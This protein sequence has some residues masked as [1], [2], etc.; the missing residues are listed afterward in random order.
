MPLPDGIAGLVHGVPAWFSR[1]L[2]A[3]QSQV[4]TGTQ[5]YAQNTDV[6]DRAN[7]VL[8]R[9]NVQNDITIEGGNITV[10]DGNITI[11]GGNIIVDS[12]NVVSTDLG[13]AAARAGNGI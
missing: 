4:P 8:G 13:L 7:R 6:A 10:D 12:G 2:G 1:L 9:V 3:G 11:T 5:V